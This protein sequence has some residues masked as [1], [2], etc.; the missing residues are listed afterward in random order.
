MRRIKS[1]P[2]VLGLFAIFTGSEGFAFNSFRDAPTGTLH[3]LSGQDSQTRAECF[4]YVTQ[5]I[6]QDSKQGP[7][8]EITVET[9]YAHNGQRAEPVTAR[10]NPSRPTVMTGTAPNSKDQ[11]ALLFKS[12][13]LDLSEMTQFNLRWWHQNHYHT[14]SCTNLRL[15]TNSLW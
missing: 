15:V 13:R 4:L 8:R 2:V 7:L 6:P 3:V 14:N 9:S 5:M 12:H 11:V 10:P 1:L